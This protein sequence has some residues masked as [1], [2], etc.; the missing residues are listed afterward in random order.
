MV[1]KI[2]TSSINKIYSATEN[3]K[4]GACLLLLKFVYFAN[5]AIRGSL[6][7]QLLQKQ[8][9]LHLWIYYMSKFLNTSE[10]IIM[11]NS[12]QILNLS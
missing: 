6:M 3:Y 2:P 12:R 8:H 11:I 7:Q 1:V 5:A 10:F 9:E 4:K